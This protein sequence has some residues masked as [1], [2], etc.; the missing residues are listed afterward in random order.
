MAN[1]LTLVNSLTFLQHSGDRMRDILFMGE[2]LASVTHDMQN[3]MAII[4]ES[5]ALA[6]D[7]LALNGRPR[8]KHGEK[9]TEALGNVQQQVLRGRELMLMLNGFAHAAED[10]PE[11]CDLCRFTKQICVLANR[12]VRMKECRLAVE[13]HA[14]PLPVS[15]SAFKVMQGAY[16]AVASV[17]AGCS[18]GDT[19]TVAAREGEGASEGGRLRIASEV[20]A[21]T[22]E[23]AG[24]RMVMEYLGATCA[25]GPGRLELIFPPVMEG[26]GV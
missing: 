23:T 3:V 18:K 7:I 22:P 24:L 2:I 21:E 5:G 1:P 8:L 16:L 17:L 26:E 19:L 9:L 15:G 12:M 20:N 6:D 13:L 25:A 11:R 4:K 14:S 10:Y